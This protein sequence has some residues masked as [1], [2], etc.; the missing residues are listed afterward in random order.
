MSPCRGDILSQ[1]RRQ[2]EEA[3]IMRDV[4][5]L[6]RELEEALLTLIWPSLEQLVEQATAGV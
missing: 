2:V 6:L 5:R 4:G 3:L 1:S